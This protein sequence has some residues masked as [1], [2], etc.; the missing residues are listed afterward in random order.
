MVINLLIDVKL[1]TV[2][3]NKCVGVKGSIE[4]NPTSTFAIEATPLPCYIKHIVTGR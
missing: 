4:H 3:F 1:G 2:Q